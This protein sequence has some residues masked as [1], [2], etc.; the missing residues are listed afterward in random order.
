MTAFKQSLENNVACHK[1]SN[2]KAFEQFETD[3]LESS[4]SDD[5]ESYSPKSVVMKVSKWPSVKERRVRNQIERIRLE[6]SHLGEDIGEC[7]VAYKVCG[8]DVVDVNVVIFSRP[9][10]PLSGKAMARIQP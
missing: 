10:S 5:M 1:K 3:R 9:A 6:D 7:L 8:S 2:V 4:S